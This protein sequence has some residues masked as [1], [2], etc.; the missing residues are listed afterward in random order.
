VTGFQ[1]VPFSCKLSAWSIS[2][3]PAAGGTATVKV[4]KIAA[5][6]AAPTS[7]NSI[8]TSGIALSSGSSVRSTT[9]SDFT[10]TTFTQG[11]ILG[12]N[13]LTVA[14]ATQVNVTLECIQ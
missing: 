6:T 12:F 8:N 7:S 5:G 10:T 2:V 1:T 13:L 14:T 9:L 11:E 3:D 4:W